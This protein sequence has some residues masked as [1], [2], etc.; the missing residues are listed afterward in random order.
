[1]G[2]AASSYE[3]RVSAALRFDES[4]VKC[5]ASWT[6]R[7]SPEP[8]CCVLNYAAVTP[9]NAGFR[10]GGPGSRKVKVMKRKLS[11][12]AAAVVAAEIAVAATPAGA[13][14]MRLNQSSYEQ[15]SAVTPV[16][17]RG[18]GR[19]RWRGGRGDAGAIIGGLAAGAIIGGLLA[20]PRYRDYYYDDY[21]EPRYVRPRVRYERRG[22]DPHQEWC[23]SRWRSYDIYS[24]TY[25]PYN[26]PRRYC[27]SPYN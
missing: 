4:S 19:G 12:I 25:Q 15:A 21:Y 8:K 13:A 17:H 14:P 24:D 23:L 11:L 26:G 27:V 16:N 5:T 3:G 6:D 7:R 18:W 2:E 20:A 1:V 10:Q 9:E 22:L